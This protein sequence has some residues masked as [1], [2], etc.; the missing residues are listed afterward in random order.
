MSLQRIKK[1][2]E[3]LQTLLESAYFDI[4]EYLE[5]HADR[6]QPFSDDL[7]QKV[8]E[9]G[10]IHEARQLFRTDL[11]LMLAV[12]CDRKDM[13]QKGCLDRAREVQAAPDGYLDLWARDHY[14]ST[15]ITFGM[16]IFDILRSHGEGAYTD[17]KTIAIFSFTAPIA[18]AFLEQIKREFEI[19]EALKFFYSD[20]FY[21]DPQKEAPKWS[22]DR[23]ILV[24]RKGNPKEATIEA[25]GVVEGQ[26][27]SK[28]FDIC[29]YDDMLSPDQALTRY[30]MFKATR[31]WEMSLNLTNRHGVARY[32]GTRQHLDDTYSTIIDRE[33]AIPRIYNPFINQ[34]DGE[35][36]LK[37]HGELRKIRRE[38]G[39]LTWASQ[40]LQKPLA[41]S[42]LALDVD[43]LVTHHISNFSK[44]NVYTIGDPSS[45][46]KKTTG[47]NQNDFTALLTVGIDPSGNIVII[48][49]V[50][51]RLNPSQR[52]D[53]L[54]DQK[55]TYRPKRIFYEDT[56][57][58]ADLFHF[59]EYMGNEG[60]YFANIIEPLTPIGAKETR[61][62]RLEPFFTNHRILVPESLPR[63]TVTK[64][65]YDGVAILKQEEIAK[66]P[67]APHDDILDCLAY[68]VILLEAKR[69][70][71]PTL[72]RDNQDLKNFYA[73]QDNYLQ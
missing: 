39:S 72:G 35:G 65:W 14:K 5:K 15:I 43:A 24:K 61:I 30:S 2:Y 46:K 18:K 7:A 33:A 16:T 48:D 41:E 45:G 64:Q 60:N 58:C 68:V 3:R 73:T 26:P 28:H 29:V 66:F 40:Y 4:G 47:R 51:D 6:L 50:R 57:L 11:F 56:G 49:I 27:T 67:F 12:L 9:V 31:A 34:H 70:L 25:W 13:L 71:I 19:N 42:A 53:A 55:M 44:M 37:T 23:G 1:D 59:K 22:L 62:M 36:W 21:Q 8:R 69:I 52:Y 63:Y 20:I 17:E 10:D 32:V 54:R 38:Q